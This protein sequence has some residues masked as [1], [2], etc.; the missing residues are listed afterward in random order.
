MKKEL[1][2]IVYQSLRSGKCYPLKPN[3]TEIDLD[4]ELT[5]FQFER[6][7]QIGQSNIFREFQIKRK[8]INPKA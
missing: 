3:G 7:K 1:P 5:E 2:E 8:R 4:N 6:Y